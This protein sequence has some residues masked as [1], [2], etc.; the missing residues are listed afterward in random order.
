MKLWR[1]LLE[2]WGLSSLKVKGPFL[3]LEFKPSDQTR[4]A[5]WSL[6]VEL[7]TRIAT[8]PLA[9]D[10]GEE[11]SALASLHSLFATTREVLRDN[12][13]KS[14]D[15]AY[16]AVPF[17][18]QVVRPFTAKWHKRLED[19]TLKSQ[20]ETKQEFRTDL[21]VIRKLVLGYTDLMGELAGIEAETLSRFSPE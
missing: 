17:L 10:E 5:A 13:P 12:G 16:I 1:D 11:I 8:Q 7:I 9:T 4:Q 21:A 15:L 19:G 14:V 6:Y 20:Q 3:E 2:K 18:N